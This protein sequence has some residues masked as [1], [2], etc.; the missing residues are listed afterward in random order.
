MSVCPFGDMMLL[1]RAFILYLSLSALFGNQTQ[2]KIIQEGGGQTRHLLKPFIF[3]L[4]LD[5][6]LHLRTV[7]LT[8][9]MM[10]MPEK[11]CIIV[12]EEIQQYA[13]NCC[14]KK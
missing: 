7:A 6:K 11:P 4:R 9:F 10:S 2:P 12:L 14:L 1:S 3:I 5:K 8:T 13:G